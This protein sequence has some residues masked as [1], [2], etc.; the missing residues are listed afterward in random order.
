MSLGTLGP[1]LLGNILAG[2]KSIGQVNIK[3][4][5]EQVN[6]LYELVMVVIPLKS[7]FNSTSSFN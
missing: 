7:I 3:E 6:E 5:I 1:S 2:E 4:W